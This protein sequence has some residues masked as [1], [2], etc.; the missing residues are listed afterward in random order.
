[1]AAA[2]VS[3]GMLFSYAVYNLLTLTDMQKPS[4]EL[5]IVDGLARDTSAVLGVVMGMTLLLVLHDRRRA[6]RAH[7]RP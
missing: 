1:M 2:W 4:P 7:P 6:L 3:S 5:P